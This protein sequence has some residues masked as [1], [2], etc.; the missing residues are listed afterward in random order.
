MV[1]RGEVDDELE[2]ETAEECAKFG[3]VI[4]CTV[5]EVADSTVP[6]SGEIRDCLYNIA[7]SAAIAVSYCSFS[8]LAVLGV[9]LCYRGCSYLRE[10]YRPC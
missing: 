8:L 1:G 5:L 2:G 9:L 10:V 3:P 7:C 4:K 6:D